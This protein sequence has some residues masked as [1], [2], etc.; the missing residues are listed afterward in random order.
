MARFN[1]YKWFMRTGDAY[2]RNWKPKVGDKVFVS[3]DGKYGRRQ[4]GKVVKRQPSTL[5]IE[6]YDVI[7][8]KTLTFKAN[9]QRGNFYNGWC[10]HED[11]LMPMLWF[12]KERKGDY[13]SVLPYRKDHDP[14]YI[15]I[16]EQQHLDENIF[17]ME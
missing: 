2:L 4:V 1:S 16:R 15:K 6:F 9:R 7:S 11:A 10:D 8:E 14:E 12:M 13:Y 3:Y 17:E 5:T